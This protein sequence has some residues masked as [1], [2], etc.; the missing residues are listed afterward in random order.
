MPLMLAKKMIGWILLLVVAEIIM[1][2]VAAHFMSW[3]VLWWVLLAVFIGLG[4]M[5]NGMGDLMPQ[6]QRFQQMQATRALLPGAPAPEL[7]D[8]VAR[9]VAGLL[10]AVPGLITDVLGLLLLIPAVRRL[11][12]RKIKAYATANQ[13]K[14]MQ[15][16]QAQMKAQGMDPSQFGGMGGMG[17]FG[18]AGQ[19][20]FAGFG[21]QAK[22]KNAKPTTIDGEARR[23]EQ[24]K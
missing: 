23:I 20:P 3:W 4:M 24:R 9:A 16:M 13:A 22:P 7:G 19:N 1:F 2:I 17:G 18:G 12:T 5:R 14:I 21:G 8:G 11:L 15:M 10:I 6:V